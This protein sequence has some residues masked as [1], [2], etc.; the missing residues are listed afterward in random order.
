MID[1]VRWQEPWSGAVVYSNVLGSPELPGKTSD[2]DHLVSYCTLPHMALLETPR[3][4][5]SEFSNHPTE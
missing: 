3:I 5:F 1:G 4:H 2:V